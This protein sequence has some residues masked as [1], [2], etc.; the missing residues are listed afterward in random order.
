MFVERMKHYC[1]SNIFN[2]VV[3]DGKK[4]KVIEGLEKKRKQDYNK[5]KV[6]TTF[7][8]FER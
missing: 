3:V 1:Q 8:L 2:I 4:I 6:V 7:D 5:L